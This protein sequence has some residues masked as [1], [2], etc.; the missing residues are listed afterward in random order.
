MSFEW[1][2]FIVCLLGWAGTV[3]LIWSRRTLITMLLFVMMTVW[4]YLSGVLILLTLN[5]PL[6]I[7]LLLGILPVIVVAYG[8][9]IYDH[10]V[11]D[12]KVKRDDSDQRAET[13]AS[14]G[15]TG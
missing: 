7:W 2:L 5:P 10:R 12:N 13:T 3:R 14:E 8:Y 9:R 6:E 11:K 1:I 15:Q 4:L